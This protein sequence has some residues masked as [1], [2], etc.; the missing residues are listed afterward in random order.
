MGQNPNRFAP[1]EHPIQSPLKQ[2]KLGGE[3]TYPKVVPLVLTH[4]H[5][6]ICFPN[7]GPVC[8]CKEV[9]MLMK[10]SLTS[11][12]HLQ[13]IPNGPIF[14]ASRYYKIQPKHGFQSGG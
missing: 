3:F 10:T 13:M 11:Y 6:T 12:N 9:D 14:E 2:T 7:H 5:L 4:S 8:C 1:S